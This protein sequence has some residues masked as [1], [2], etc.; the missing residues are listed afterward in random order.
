MIHETGNTEV[1][2]AD[3]LA[4]DIKL[5]PRDW[6][7]I[8]GVEVHDDDGWRNPAQD[9]EV[10]VTREEFLHRC[11]EST[12]WYPR[13]FFTGLTIKVTTNDT[14]HIFD[15]IAPTPEAASDLKKCFPP[16]STKT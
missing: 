6:E 2:K 7:R 11:S 9:Y 10:P 16:S 3:L 15:M 5:P 8:T 13:E 1:F 14:N 4:A 12:C